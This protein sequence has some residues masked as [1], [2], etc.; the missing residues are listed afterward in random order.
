LI[1]NRGNFFYR[2]V[3][4]F[5]LCA[6]SFCPSSTP[7]SGVQSESTYGISTILRVSMR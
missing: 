2:D 1:V 3:T 7:H 4:K 6:A 5:R